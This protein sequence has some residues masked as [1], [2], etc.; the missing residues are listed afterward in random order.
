ML[1]IIPGMGHVPCFTVCTDTALFMVLGRQGEKAKSMLI[2]ESLVRSCVDP[3][4]RQTGK[5]GGGSDVAHNIEILHE[6]CA[7]KYL[8]RR[9]SNGFA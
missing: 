3:S 2:R 1:C 8:G 9:K 5:E 4:T 6:G 7:R